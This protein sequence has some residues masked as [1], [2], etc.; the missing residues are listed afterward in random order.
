MILR[1]IC[2]FL[3]FAGPSV[4]F[5]A[6]SLFW[7]SDPV[8]PGESVL[9]VGDGFK[10]GMRVAVRQR[11]VALSDGGAKTDKGSSWTDVEPLQVSEKSVKF[12]IPANFI[13]GVYEVRIG[14]GTDTVAGMINEPVIYWV[15]GDA[16]KSAFPAGWIRLVGRSLNVTEAS[17]VLSLI[18]ADGA[19]ERTLKAVRSSLWEA[20]FS[21]PADMSPGR[22]VIRYGLSEQ[23]PRFW[24]TAGDIE[25]IGRGVEGKS[26][27]NVKDHGARGDGSV[28]DTA[29]VRMAID[30]A[31]NSGGGTIY[32]PRGRYMLTDTIVIPQNI[33]LQGE[34]RDLV[35]VI[36]P[37]R[38]T[39][40]QFLLYGYNHF[41][42][43]DM[44]IYASNHGHV[45]ASDLTPSDKGAPGNVK[46]ERV[47]IRA[48][49]YRGHLKP[50]QVDSRFRE[51]LKASSGG[52]DTIRLG[53][54][55]IILT[56]SDV[57]GSGRALFLFKPK[58]AYI[59]R[60]LLYNG[61]WGWYVITGADGVI[62]EDNVITGGDLMSTGG[63]INNLGDVA[64]SKNV[65]FSRNKFT[66]M[67]GW[68]REAV[69]SDAG[70]GYYYG[71]VRSL[72]KN[73]LELQ[74]EPVAKQ[75]AKNGW[76]YAGVFILGGKGMGQYG[77]VDRLEGKNVYLDRPWK[78][79]PDE[80]SVITITMMQ[81]NYIFSDND[82]V[83]AGMGIQFY[84]TSVGHIVSGN[85]STRT[86]G[87]VARGQWYRHF[88]PSWYCQFLDNEILEGNIYRSGPNN[89][90]QSGEAV[91][92]V[93]GFQKEPNAAPLSIGSIVRRNHLHSNS[94][95]EVIGAGKKSPGMRDVI[96]ENNIIENADRGII[97]DEGSRDVLIRGNMFKNIKSYELPA[98]SGL[99]H[100]H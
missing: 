93:Y 29:A 80:T 63:G 69:T 10:D 23:G 77:Q 67:H 11:S 68:D 18:I 50:E 49:A 98:G 9:T 7:V 58:N 43:S 51:S 13:K 81:Q 34:R 25:I 16:G 73:V 31:R 22:Y 26:P 12:I 100:Y 35:N 62:F 92:G 15:Q 45:I 56:D 5:C 21:I 8:F 61:R 41:A 37:D 83:D 72:S 86:G 79:Q 27:F 84:G 6:P 76:K 78:V 54:E 32:F 95:I 96:V 65:L 66:L 1:S 47:T 52:Y 19:G 89:A 30:A 40:L 42:L 94:H 2:F 46:I 36:W 99:I 75:E 28:D 60:N 3:L 88:Q 55:N 39:P 70:G 33:S 4:A 20:Q 85:R 38:E 74:E 71:P 44:T 53:G 97:V 14:K 91:I 48:N 57:Y 59:A 64:A 82:F 87:F 17:P 24:V 90:I